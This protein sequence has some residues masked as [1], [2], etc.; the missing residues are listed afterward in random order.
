MAIS[1][2][3][4]TELPTSVVSKIGS[5]PVIVDRSYAIGVETDLNFKRI[6]ELENYYLNTKAKYKVFDNELEKYGNEAEIELIWKEQNQSILPTSSDVTLELTNGGSILLLEQLPINQ[7]VEFIEI[8]SLSR[9]GA[10]S[11]D[12]FPIQP[13]TKLSPEELLQTRY[14]VPPFG[15]GIPFFEFE[16]KVG[17]NDIVEPNVYNF[18][19]NIPPLAEMEESYYFITD[20][21]IETDDLGNNFTLVR[22]KVQFKIRKG[23]SLKKA[24][25]SFELNSPFIETNQFTSTIITLGGQEIEKNISVDNF[26]LELELNASGIATIYVENVVAY[27]QSPQI[28]NL[29]IDLV[30]IDNNPNWVNSDY[31]S[32]TIPTNI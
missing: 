28:G 1:N 2:F 12:N 11:N 30:S 23:A 10:L 26:D 32:V 9:S 13:G 19:V 21:F 6:P 29:K 15:T 22:Q 20:P 8:I 25:L 5:S 24:Q 31:S 18:S 16:Y 17:R 27:N 7:S 4:I 3:K 14:F